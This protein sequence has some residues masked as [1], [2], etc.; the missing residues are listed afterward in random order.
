MWK[1]SFLA[2]KISSFL[3]WEQTGTYVS[4]TSWGFFFS[5]ETKAHLFYP[6]PVQEAA[7][8]S[9]PAGSTVSDKYSTI[10]TH[11]PAEFHRVSA[12]GMMKSASRR[13]PGVKTAGIPSP[14]LMENSWV[15]LLQPLHLV[16]TLPKGACIIERPKPMPTLWGRGALPACY[17]VHPHSS[18]G[19]VLWPHLLWPQHN[20]IFVKIGTLFSTGYFLFM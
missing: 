11:M 7:P 12:R 9:Q 2:G 16:R 5:K 15:F 1:L 19:W 6:V 14:A 18:V 13:H 3:V 17:L 10:T 4:K 20:F 8:T